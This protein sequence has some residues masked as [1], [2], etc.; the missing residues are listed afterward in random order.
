MSVNF[1]PTEGAP[2][3]FV[4]MSGK[5][6]GTGHFADVPMTE[7]SLEGFRKR[8]IGDS[9][10]PVTGEDGSVLSEDLFFHYSSGS[11]KFP[12]Q[13]ENEG[14]LGAAMRRAALDPANPWGM[15]P[16]GD[17]FAT[18]IEILDA[19][20]TVGAA[21]LRRYP[22]PTDAGEDAAALRVKLAAAIK[23]RE[24]AEKLVTIRDAT[25]EAER[26]A[27][28]ALRDLLVSVL[29]TVAELA[30]AALKKAPEA[31]KGGVPARTLH[32]TGKALEV[33]VKQAREKM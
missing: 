19:A 15:K 16:E 25:L 9:P 8:Y 14:P 3:S 23:A 1:K 28:V 17:G 27:Y 5:P 13:G 20:A 2:T 10:S 24:D 21:I 7:A 29:N 32:A 12:L 4:W 26:K 22:A 6:A 11:L 31:N 30:A 33:L 18:G